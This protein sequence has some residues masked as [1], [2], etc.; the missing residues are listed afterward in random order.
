MERE[1]LRGDADPNVKYGTPLNP[2]RLRHIGTLS[3]G[4]VQVS[5]LVSTENRV[6]GALKSLF[7]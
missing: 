6:V 5:V 7:K 1:G 3:A 4:K 2:I